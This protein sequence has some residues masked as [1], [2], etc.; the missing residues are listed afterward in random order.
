ML[1]P[2][3]NMALKLQ[4]RKMINSLRNWAKKTVVSGKIQLFDYKFVNYEIKN[5]IKF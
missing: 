4:R 2:F 5:S 3:R 1:F